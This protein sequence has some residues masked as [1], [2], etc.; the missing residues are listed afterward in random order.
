[1]LADIAGDI[2][3][4]FD[5][6]GYIEEASPSIN[7]IGLDPTQMLLKP[8]LADL[9]QATHRDL[10]ATFV[11]SALIHETSTEW[12]EFPLSLCSAS[13]CDI[14]SPW[15]A[16]HARSRQSAGGQQSGGIALLR[17]V[18]R[19]RE[20]EQ[21][22]HAQSSV[23]PLTGLGNSRSFAASL[24]RSV[25]ADTDD[26]LAVFELGQFRA[27][28]LQYGQEAADELLWAF[29]QFLDAMGLHKLEIAHLGHQRFGVILDGKPI[30]AAQEWCDDV[31]Q[32]L[33]ALA[34]GRTSKGVQL[35]AS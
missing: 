21:E 35:S 33:S 27:L 17:S 1:M 31:L 22:L 3:I 28:H 6:D 19:L 7:A 13:T 16:L 24:Q 4:T 29:A 18:D 26:T 2:V 15:Y 10:A 9:A 32:T 11:A 5:C 20:L 30:D 34:I 8:H 14:H 25:A 12:I 23:D